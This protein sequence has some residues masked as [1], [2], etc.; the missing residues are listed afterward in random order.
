MLSEAYGTE[1]CSMSME[2]SVSMEVL[3]GEIAVKLFEHIALVTM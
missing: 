1:A 3:L 2:V